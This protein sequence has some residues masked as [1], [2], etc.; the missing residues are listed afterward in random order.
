MEVLTLPDY[1]IIVGEADV[2]MVLNNLLARRET[3]SAV[4]VLVDEHTR[5]HCLPILETELKRDDL[6]II[7][8]PS[9]EHYKTIK[10][11][12]GIWN[13]MLESGADRRSLVINL[14]GGVI[15]DMGGFCAA[16]FKRGVDFIQMPT[17]LLAQVDASVGGKLGIDFNWG[18]GPAIKNCIGLFQS[19]HA[20]LIWPD[21]LKT[22]PADQLRSGFA[23]VIKHALVADADM[24]QQLIAIE[25]FDQVNWQSLIPASIEIKRKVV[26]QDPFEKGLRKILNFG[27][28]IGHAI[29]SYALNTPTP[30]LHGEAVAV[31]M[32]CEAWISHKEF[33]LKYSEL[34]IITQFILHHFGKVQFPE[35]SFPILLDI[36]KQD[37]KNLGTHIN[38]SLLRSPGAAVIDQTCDEERILDSLKY[39]LNA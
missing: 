19:P 11:C 34:Q 9:G 4:M 14:G 33:V 32:I 27:H 31:G 15:G 29:E 30:L 12:E 36:M 28:T 3:D 7:E 5:E 35:S 8:I 20:V 18:N 38:F 26:E 17:T 24:W 1:Q 21:F 37:K 39:Y 6:H 2:W 23:E 13:A 10:T 25:S 16:T 22:L